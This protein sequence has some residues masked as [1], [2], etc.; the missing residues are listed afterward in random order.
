MDLVRDFDSDV[1]WILEACE[2]RV[3]TYPPSLRQAGRA[4]LDKYQLSKKTSQRKG[5]IYLLPFWLKETLGVDQEACR[6]S[7]LGITFGTL[8]FFVQDAVIDTRPGEYK[9]HLLPLGSLFFLDFIA[10]YRSLF[11]PH[12][13]FWDFFEK[14]IQEWAESVLWER[15]QH[16]GK[17]REYGEEDLIRLGRKAAPLKTP[18]TAMSLL[19]GREDAIDLLEEM[20]DYNLVVVQLMDDLRDWR[21]DLARGNYTYFLTRV[22][23]AQGIC[24]P[25][26]LTEAE[27]EKALFIGKVFEEVLDLAAE[28]NWRTLESISALRAPYLEAYIDVLAQQCRQLKGELQAERARRIREQFAFLLQGASAIEE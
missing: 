26:S 1:E 23:A 20:L 27:V 5:L 10:P 21:G 14:Y 25:A 22:M 4:F 3:S 7:A 13:P 2:R 12:S 11:D 15:E 8:Y 6:L 18:C 28:Y 9:G 24:S 17:V 16:W 19:A